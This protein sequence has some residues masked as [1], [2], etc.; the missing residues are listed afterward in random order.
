MI[1]VED[2]RD[3]FAVAQQ[4]ESVLQELSYVALLS[5]AS[6]IYGPGSAHLMCN[7]ECR[8]GELGE[9][10]GAYLALNII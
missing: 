1:E 7:Q 5:D 8:T 10:G 3:I 6:R 4:D 2:R 9:K